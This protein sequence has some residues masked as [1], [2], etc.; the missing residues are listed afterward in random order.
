MANSNFPNGF[1]SG[2]TIRGIPLQQLHPGEV[3]WVNNSSV[4]AYGQDV[5]GS[6]GNDGSFRKPF[7]SIT[8]ALTQCKANRGD[9]IMLGIGHNDLVA[10]AAAAGLTLNVAGV[11]IVGTGVGSL[12]SA[13]TSTLTDTTIDITAANQSFVNISF[14]ASI[15]EVAIG[16]DISDVD[17]LSFDRCIFQAQGMAADT[18][19]YVIVIELATGA[20]DFSMSNCEF[21]GRDAN[22]DACINGGIHDRLSL[23]NCRFFNVVDPTA[24]G[25]VIFSG[26]LTNL[27]VQN[28][29]FYSNVDGAICFQGV[30][31]VQVLLRIALLAVQTRMAF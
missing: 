4:L 30:R 11:A 26:A 18:N 29:D 2:V 5:T 15:G 9:I 16:L 14:E 17:G 8:Y 24:T 31:Q 3:F 13:I 27:N 12:K 21:Y 28:C 6:N 22:N 19:N 23:D 10:A 7:S 20:A 25:T 1:A